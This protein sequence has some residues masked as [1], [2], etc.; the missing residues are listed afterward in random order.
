MKKKRVSW[1]DLE[2][3]IPGIGL[4]DYE[5]ETA[6]QV[7]CMDWI[8]KRYEV[9]KS[10]YYLNWHHSGNERDNSRMGFDCKMMGQAKGMLDLVNFR[11]K[12]AF[13]FKVKG[14][15]ASREQVDWILHFRELGWLS[16]VVRRF[17]TFKFLVERAIKRAEQV[18]P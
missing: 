16:G 17:E 7:F 6:F 18:G 12:L 13:E 1:C 14:R 3:F 9:S 2:V 4:T 8:R 15:K 10:K 5:K 11:L